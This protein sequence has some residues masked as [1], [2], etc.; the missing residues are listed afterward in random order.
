[1]THKST[2]NDVLLA[3][4]LGDI[5]EI[6]KEVELIKLALKD[7]A[8]MVAS[9]IKDQLSEHQKIYSNAVL[10][11]ST[12]LGRSLDTQF[13][14][15]SQE[16]GKQNAESVAAA[17]K[18][19]SGL[20]V[21]AKKEISGLADKIDSQKLLISAVVFAVVFAVGASYLTTRLTMQ[22]MIKTFGHPVEQD[23]AKT[24]TAKK[25]RKH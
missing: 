22:E 6:K 1:M 8:G 23:Q 15:L 14:R 21:A 13:A 10:E 11:H 20:T 3:E 24:A 7:G 25:R 9:D 16:A 12:N 17:K 19:L 5:Y 2:V 18:E 4:V